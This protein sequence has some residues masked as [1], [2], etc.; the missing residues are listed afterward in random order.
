[1]LIVSHEK[2]HLAP[3][4]YL[5]ILVA[6]DIINVSFPQGTGGVNHHPQR[7]GIHDF[8][9]IK[10]QYTTV[11]FGCLLIGRGGGGGGGG[12]CSCGDKYKYH[13][14]RRQ[15]AVAVSSGHYACGISHRRFFI[16]TIIVVNHFKKILSM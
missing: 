10:G 13:F 11:L 14:N 9:L 12:G 7:D 6:S 15:C 1:M 3:G 16:S 2:V 8:R 5:E 4:P